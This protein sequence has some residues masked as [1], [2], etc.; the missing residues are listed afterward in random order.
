M[1]NFHKNGLK[2]ET[3][4]RVLLSINEKNLFNLSE[5]N[6]YKSFLKKSKKIF[7]FF[8]IH[9]IFKLNLIKSF[10]HSEILYDA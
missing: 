9:K 5:P 4:F 6:K 10:F 7:R 1:L 8:L 3:S 2:V